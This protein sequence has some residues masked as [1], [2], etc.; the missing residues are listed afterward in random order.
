MFEPKQHR[1]HHLGR[2]EWL[3]WDLLRSCGSPCS[4]SEE[5][6]P[7][8]VNSSFVRFTRKTLLDPTCPDSVEQHRCRSWKNLGKIILSQMGKFTECSNPVLQSYHDDSALDE[9]W[10]DSF[11]CWRILTT[12]IQT[13][14]SVDHDKHGHSQTWV[15]GLKMVDRQYLNFDLNSSRFLNCWLKSHFTFHNFFRR[16]VIWC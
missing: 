7:N 2:K 15:S 14:S 11:C 1:L 4:P 3:G 10:D 6:G 5:L 16:W 8:S 9:I 13:I 12:S